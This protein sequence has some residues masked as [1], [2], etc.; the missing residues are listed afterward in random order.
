MCRIDY[1]Y[2]Q[3]FLS[4][5]NISFLPFK[6]LSFIS[7]CM[8]VRVCVLFFLITD[9][10]FPWLNL[11]KIFVQN[12]CVGRMIVSW[13]DWPSSLFWVFVWR[14][15]EVEFFKY[16]CLVQFQDL[17]GILQ[18]LDCWFYSICI[19]QQTPNLHTSRLIL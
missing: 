16:F 10:F 12:L 3:Y 8:Y 13:S 7:L 5:E 2:R 14:N 9:E 6:I 17:V 1:F 15:L 11:I 19:L 4:I 18:H